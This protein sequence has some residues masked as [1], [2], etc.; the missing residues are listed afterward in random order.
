MLGPLSQ[1]GWPGCPSSQ[2]RW[3]CSPT[4]QTPAP[5]SRDSRTVGHL[6]GCLCGTREKNCVCCGS[7]APRAQVRTLVFMGH[8][9][10]VRQDQA[11]RRTSEIPQPRCA[12]WGARVSPLLT[13]LLS[14]WNPGPGQVEKETQGPQPQRRGCPSIADRRLM[15]CSI[16]GSD[17]CLQE[18]DRA[19]SPSNPGASYTLIGT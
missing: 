6:E 19:S 17:L 18:Q 4:N 9:W 7:T 15:E 1:S 8:A 16:T 14:E 3:L 2:Q 5:P 13:C 11:S 12:Q 10:G